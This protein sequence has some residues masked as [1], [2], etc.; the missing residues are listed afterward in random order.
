[1]DSL[2]S[3]LGFWLGAMLVIIFG[4]HIILMSIFPRYLAE[5]QVL[6]RLKHDAEYIDQYLPVKP[7]E[8]LPQ[9]IVTPIYQVPFSGHYFQIVSASRVIRSPS[10][11]GQSL[12]LPALNGTSEKVVKITGPKQAPLL[13][14]IKEI[15][16]DK[17]RF[18]VAVAEEI[19]DIEHD[20]AEQQKIYLL[21][22][23][24][25]LLLLVLLQRLLIRR[26][27]KPVD[28]ARQ[29]L[30]DIEQ[31]QAV[32]ITQKVPAEIQPLVDE[33]NHLL[34]VMHKRLERSRNATGNL[35]HAL[36]T[37]L[38]V[39]NQLQD[40]PEIRKNKALGHEI[41]QI[42]QSIQTSIDRE[43]KRARLS[44][45]VASP[46]KRNFRLAYEIEGLI[47]VMQKVYAQK[48]LQFELDI[49]AAK[50]VQA[51][52]EDML[53]MLGNLLDNACKWAKSRVRI[54]VSDK[55]GFE[56]LIED[57]GEGVSTAQQEKIQQQLTQRGSRLDERKPGHG[58]GLSITREIVEQYAGQIHF[59]NS[60]SLGGFRVLIQF[61]Q[62]GEK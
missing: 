2:Q 48:Q 22:S 44:G 49:P 34:D 60:T 25:T 13:I 55:A 28:Q 16:K 12:S 45:G 52:R 56:L 11:S 40:T 54:S 6:R 38:S 61:P 9:S 18:I 37:P 51:D 41:H 46:A 35:A 33:I 24:I 62:S 20:I 42:S 4:V 14:L 29:Q 10:L 31:G 50:I 17:Q 5:E 30:L 1:M 32:K 36:K 59:G 7:G 3:R 58:L 21:L 27:I 47:S 8:H 39:L 19:K 15:R 43:L 57:D 53:E 26:A 23:T